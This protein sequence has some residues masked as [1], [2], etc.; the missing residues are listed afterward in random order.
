MV[1]QYSARRAGTRPK[2]PIVVLINENTAS[3]AEIVAG[4]LH[5]H[6]R[7][8][9]VGV[10]TFGKGSVQNVF[11]LPDGSALKLTTYRY[12]TPSGNSIQAEGISPDLLAEQPR[13]E[14]DPEPFREEELDGHLAAQSKGLGG[15]ANAPAPNQ[16]PLASGSVPKMLAEDSQG[17]R[18]YTVLK[19]QV[20]GR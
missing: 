1:G 4:A 2:W 19:S 10:R 15:S 12:Y 11:E 20:G 17:Q 7:A 8:E 16:A 9:L 6:H 14:G 18:A 5:D 3:A 13:P